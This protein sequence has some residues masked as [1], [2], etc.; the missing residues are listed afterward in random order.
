M[1][2]LTSLPHDVRMALRSLRHRPGFAFLVVLTLALGIGVNVA[3]VS[4]VQALLLRPLPFPEADRLVRVMAFKGD[5]PGRIA[6]REVEDLRRQSQVFESVA[7][8]YLSQYN[9]T[10]DGPPEAVPC[11]IGSHDLFEVLGA[12]FALGESFPAEQDYSMQFRVVLSYDFWQRRLGGA[13]DVIG[14]SIMLDGGAY[15]I[16]GVL[17]AG[18]SFPPDVGLYRQVTD[19][20]GLDKRRHSV[21][22]RMADGYSL[23]QTREELARLAARWEEQYPQMNRGVHFEVM[24]LRDA[25]VGPARPYLATLAIAVAFVLLIAIVNTVHLLLARASDR[26]PEM[27]VRVALGAGRWHLVRQ[28]LVESLLLACLGGA[29]G[30]ALAVGLMRLFEGWI[31]ADLPS[32]M[33]IRLDPTVFAVAAGLILLCGAIAGL[34]PAWLAS[35]SATGANSASG[36][37][38]TGGQASARLR[39]VLVTAEIALALVLLVGA[40]L[41]TRSTL[42]LE[43]QDLGFDAENLFTI[44]TDPPWWSYN[45]TEHMVPFFDQVMEHLAQIPG[46]TGVAA[47]QNLPL[48]GLDGST[49]RVVTLEGQAAE[50]QTANP[51]IHLQSVSSGY[52][53]VMGISKLQGRTLTPQD[54]L[55]TPHVAVLSQ[56]LA[57]RL[58]PGQDVLGKRLKLGPPE[59]EASWTTVVGIVGDVRSERRSG[60]ASLDLYLSNLQHF[61]GDSYFVFRTTGAG[62]GLLQ[63]IETAIQTV[64]PDL[65]LFDIAPMA[66]RVARVEW[67]RQATSQLFALF[68]ILALALAAFGTYGVM[69]YQVAQRTQEMGIR[70][71][72]GARPRDLV[73]GVLGQGLGLL[74]KGSVIGLLAGLALVRFIE[75]QLFGV[76]A[77]DPLSLGAAWGTLLVAL[78]LACLVPSWRA[79]KLDPIVAMRESEG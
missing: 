10:G 65:P 75:G 51:F 64:D 38:G 22:A 16:D 68:G 43:Q 24:G 49:K 70:Q 14:K 29:L 33:V 54:R 28:L 57:Q 6:Q 8:Y 39:N 19:Y 79:A 69:A 30:L 3:V 55:G 44:R 36:L 59:S 35:R 13:R 76:Q 58:W 66:D 41:M 17:E 25:W 1:S 12:R 45:T 78:L 2:A 9:V 73:F 32:W 27:S 42:A 37:R 15:T 48:S 67:Q 20:H 72:F 60:D 4:W 56:G 7:S 18:S 46:V 71:A 34:L 61:T 53:D 74:L 52:F 77:M 62:E 21:V 47:N 31:H 11:A 40:S 23:E 5:E 63:Q 50:E 26:K